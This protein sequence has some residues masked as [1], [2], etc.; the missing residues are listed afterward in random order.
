MKLHI[1]LDSLY[2]PETITDW[3]TTETLVRHRHAVI[4][5]TQTHFCSWK[6]V[7]IEDELYVHCGDYVIQLVIG[8]NKSTDRL[9]NGTENL[10]RLLLCGEFDFERGNIAY[11]KL[12]S[13]C[14]SKGDETYNPCDG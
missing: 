13:P 6:Y 10:E 4:H 14:F 11:Q 5:T 7:K 8:H 12:N 3:I 1:H 2:P 9:L